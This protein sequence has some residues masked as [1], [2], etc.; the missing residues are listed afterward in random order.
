M[1]PCTASLCLEYGITT[2]M[3]LHHHYIVQIQRINVI[4]SNTDNPIYKI[5]N[6]FFFHTMC[7]E[8]S[9]SSFHS[10]N[11]LP[12]IPPLKILSPAY[13]QKGAERRE[14]QPN[15]NKQTWINKAKA[16]L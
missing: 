10:S 3:H 1:S 9:P 11:L 4:H 14:K 5:E 6:R 8:H 15:M 13:L 7:P 12:I 16:F 2:L